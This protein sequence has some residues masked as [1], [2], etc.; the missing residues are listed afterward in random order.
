ME[1]KYTI[2]Y[3]IWSYTNISIEYEICFVIQYS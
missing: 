1:N 3:N 2:F